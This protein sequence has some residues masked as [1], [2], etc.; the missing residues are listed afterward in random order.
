MEFP[1]EE[2]TFTEDTQ[3]MIGDEPFLFLDSLSVP[4]KIYKLYSFW[5]LAG[6]ALMA[7]PVT[8]PGV[9]EVKIFLPG[10]AEVKYS[11][12]VYNI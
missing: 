2:K 6:G 8:E 10:N 4:S 5:F 1:K 9:Q 7:C 12:D 3:Y 11:Q